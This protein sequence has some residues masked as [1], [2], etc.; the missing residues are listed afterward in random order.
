MLRKILFIVAIIQ[1]GLLYSQP[2][3]FSKKHEVFIV[4]LKDFMKSTSEENPSKAFDKFEKIWK[5][6][7][8]S[9]EN[10]LLIIKIADE[11]LINKMKVSPDFELYLLTLVCSKDSIKGLKDDKFEFWIKA[12]YDASKAGSSKVKLLLKT[13]K[14]M[15]EENAIYIAESKKWSYTETDFKYN[16]TKSKYLIEFNNIDLTG[17][18]IDD[19]LEIKTTSGVY[20]L[21]K[22]TWK[23]KGGKVYWTRVG[24]AQADVNAVL[25]NYSIDMSKVEFEADSVLFTNKHFLPTPL[26]G[27]LK[28]RASYERLSETQKDFKDSKYP[29]FTAYKTNMSLEKISEGLAKYNG[30]FSIQGRD[31]IGIGTAEN[32]A[33]LEFYYKNKL[34][35]K[36]ESEAFVIRD[37]RIT[38]QQTAVTILTDSGFIFHPKLNFNFNIESKKI[39]MNRGEEGIERSPFYNT[40]HGLEFYVD[41]VQWTLEQP[42]ID[43]LMN[44]KDGTARFE[45]INY[46]REFNY[47]KM[48]G[49]LNYNPVNKIQQYCIQT[50]SREFTIGQYAQWMGST[51]DKIVNQIIN[52]ADNGYIYYNPSS[53]KIKVKRKIFDYVNSHFKLTDYDVIRFRSIIGGRPNS[54]LNLVNNNFVIEGVAAFNFSD[55]QTV[56]AYPREQILYIKSK[57]NIDF[58]GKL[59]AGWFDFYSDEFKFNYLKFLV[60]SDKIDSLRLYYPDSVTGNS[61]VPVTSLLKDISGTIY[62]D[63][64]NNKSGADT[65]N[66]EYPIFVSEKSSKISYQ[67]NSI[68]KGAYNDNDFY[69]KVDP[70]TIDSIDNFT[71]SGLKFPGSFVSA[72]ILP[73]FRFE[74]KI[75]KDYS[76]GFERESPPEGYPMYKNKGNGKIDITLNDKGLTAKGEVEYLGAK[77]KSNDIVLLPDSMNSNTEL[78]TIDES[79]KYPKVKAVKVY[80]HWVPKKD[81]LYITTTSNTAEIFRNGQQFSGKMVMTPKLLSGNGLLEWD[82]AKLTSNQMKFA[83][84]SVKADTSN[85]QISTIDKQKIAFSSSNVNSYVDFDKRTGDFKANIAGQYTT[86][87][88]N[89]FASNMDQFFWEM[90]KQTILLTKSNKLK[91]SQF[92]ALKPDMDGLKFDSDKALF[93][94]KEGIIYAENVPYIDIADSRVFP[95]D[96]KVTIEKEADILPLKNAKMLAARANKYHEFF[97]ATLKILGRKSISGSGIYR[98]NDKYKTKQEIFFNKLRVLPDS[99]VQAAGFITDSIIFKIYPM[100]G[101]KGSF[102]INSN[103]EFLSFNGYVKP[104]HTFNIGSNWIRYKDRPDPKNIVIDARDPKNDENKFVSV[105]LNSALDTALIYPTFFNFKRKYADPE[106]TTDTGIFIYDELNSEF[107]VGNKDRILKDAPRG[108]I[109]TF[110]EKT[111]VISTQ[112]KLNLGFTMPVLDPLISGKIYKKEEDSSYSMDA[113][114]ALDILLPKDAYKRMVDIIKEKGESAY[115]L[116]YMDDDFKYNLGEFLSD[117]QLKSTLKKA[118]EIGEFQVEDEIKR[119]MIFS[120]V[121]FK[122]SPLNKSWFSTEPIGISVI[123]GQQINKSF[124]SRMQMQIKRSGASIKIYFELSKYDWFYFEYFRNNLVAISSDKEFNDLIRDKYSEVQKSNYNIRPGTTRTVSKFIEKFD[125]SE[126]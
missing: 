36:A 83:T 10:K 79:E 102:E 122:Y 90:D 14:S 85:I 105:S 118:T 35:L 7:K 113:F 63:K 26:Y 21:E 28:E 88:Y 44:T 75:M 54:Y 64:P 20:D 86:F 9:D 81:S 111:R 69:F 92:V 51:P 98:Y 4:E 60:H 109:I 34:K 1:F 78:F 38:S 124:T 5:T 84:N 3:S 30:G 121:R 43:F 114:M 31:I 119:K 45:S 125:E 103:N 80:N 2:K 99:T 87:A 82:N 68:Y 104:L 97:S 19:K 57:R 67:K 96:G 56:V 100:I 73:E 62:I 58:G 40:D 108:C 126:E 52:L 91:T 66:G 117:K 37:K 95:N 101:Y 116:T 46:F 41:K 112:G 17:T 8:F 61:L 94:M 74:A 27:K 93:D 55:S 49:M 48:Q 115:R 11:L 65:S 50:K 71:I 77:I 123:N 22:N 23:G 70:F 13:S 16:F 24:F 6:T 107:K 25:K 39:T 76:L 72:D 89:Q 59:T 29:Q 33:I 18:T 106:F 53:G 32:P 15:F 120:E 42:K 12:V 110:N 47:E